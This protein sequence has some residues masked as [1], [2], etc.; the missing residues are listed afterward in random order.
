[1]DLGRCASG[2]RRMRLADTVRSNPIADHA[3]GRELSVGL[4]EVDRFGFQ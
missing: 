1:M 2:E 3:L 4:W